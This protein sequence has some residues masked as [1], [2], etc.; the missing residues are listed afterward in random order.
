M[1][2]TDGFPDEICLG[3]AED[4]Y[5]AYVFRL[6][7]NNAYHQLKQLLAKTIHSPVPDDLSDEVDS[8]LVEAEESETERNESRDFETPDSDTASED[9]VNANRK[10]NDILG[11][12]DEYVEI[13]E[14][15][16][17]YRCVYVVVL[18]KC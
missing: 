3:C 13:Y 2:D 4:L 14:V 12:S 17:C 11:N 18:H 10:I 16:H 7:C 8:I 6:R 9:D 5:W 1:N 15:S